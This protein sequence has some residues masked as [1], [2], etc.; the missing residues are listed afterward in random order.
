V[1]MINDRYARLTEI[2]TSLLR[3]YRKGGAVT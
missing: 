1:A 3:S 2:R